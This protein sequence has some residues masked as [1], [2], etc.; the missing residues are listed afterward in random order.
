MSQP[1][2]YK[3][4]PMP[5]TASLTLELHTKYKRG[6]R[7]SGL[8]NYSSSVQLKTSILFFGK[9]RTDVLTSSLLG[10]GF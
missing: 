7:L 5:T 10:H 1:G 4:S 9:S 8:I 2:V 3:P 6:V